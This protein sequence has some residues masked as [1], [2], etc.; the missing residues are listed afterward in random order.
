MKIIAD[1][2]KSFEL[3][4]LLEKPLFAHLA[5]VENDLP[6]D[7]PCWFHWEDGHLWIIGTPSDTFPNRI[8]QHP[9]CA[10]GI[11]DFNPHTGLVLHAGF[12]GT[13]TVEPF[14]EIIANK[15]LARYLGPNET[16]WPPRFR[17]I[18]RSSVLVKFKPDTVVVR[19]QSYSLPNDGDVYTF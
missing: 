3:E 6:K 11:I 5:T 18:D 19:D 8:K 15:L 12:R 14:D 17:Q 13:A 16:D 7:T 4:E 1:R 2:H 9:K 10:I